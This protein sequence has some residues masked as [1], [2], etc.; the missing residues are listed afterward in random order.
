MTC[1]HWGYRSRR[2]HDRYSRSWRPRKY[3]PHRIATIL[4][5]LDRCGDQLAGRFPPYVSR[6]VLVAVPRDEA[7]NRVLRTDSPSQ[8]VL[9]TGGGRLFDTER[10][11]GF[12]GGADHGNPNCACLL[13][14]AS[15]CHT[16][17]AALSGCDRGWLGALR[18]VHRVETT[19]SLSNCVAVAG[20]VQN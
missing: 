11:E 7:N 18:E 1:R 16:A 13:L 8:S 14:L 3:M 15:T 17:A 19:Q 9:H 6:S 12:L 4:A 20:S 2:W 5:T 10:R